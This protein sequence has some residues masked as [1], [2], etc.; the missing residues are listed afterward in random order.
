MAEFVDEY[1]RSGGPIIDI[2]EF[3]YQIKLAIAALGIA[4]I[5]DA[6]SIIENQIPDL[7]SVRDRYDH[8]LKDN[9][10]ARAQLQLLVVF[11]N[12]WNAMGIADALTE[13]SSR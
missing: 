10:L 13:L 11:L 4:W 1:S 5:L 3:A 7:R 8:K 6:P 12:E 9:F 2:D